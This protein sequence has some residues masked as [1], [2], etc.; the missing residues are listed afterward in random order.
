MYV[1]G[2]LFSI[3]SHSVNTV[4]NSSPVSSA[5][6][7][8]AVIALFASLANDS[9]TPPMCGAAGKL[10]IHLMF[11]SVKRLCKRGLFI[12]LFTISCNSLVAST[13]FV[14]QLEKIFSGFDHLAMIENK[15]AQ[16]EWL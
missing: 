11:S 14:P 15:E 9:Q 12:H 16:C 2:Q 3:A 4:I 8:A 13:K 7:V 5:L 1:K 6:F 10:K